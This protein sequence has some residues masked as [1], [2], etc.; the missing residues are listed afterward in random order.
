MA[1]SREERMLEILK[2]LRSSSS[3]VQAAVLVSSDALPIASD[4]GSGM[5]EDAAT[6]IL[7]P[8]V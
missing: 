1:V 4:I 7:S 8:R 6:A 5:N 2:R 3:A